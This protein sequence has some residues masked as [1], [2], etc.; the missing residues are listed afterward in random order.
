[1]ERRVA[2]LSPHSFHVAT[3]APGMAL[4]SAEVTE[5]VTTYREGI[6]CEVL[7]VL[8]VPVCRGGIAAHRIW[9]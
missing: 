3:E 9:A 4:V 1:M 6:I 5:G 8:E 2:V 7:H